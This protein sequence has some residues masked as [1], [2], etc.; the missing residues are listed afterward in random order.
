MNYIGIIGLLLTLFS[1]NLFAQDEKDR[2]H[3]KDGRI[4]EGIILEIQPNEFINLQLE[5]GTTTKIPLDEIDRV[6]RRSAHRISSTSP[7]GSVNIPHLFESSNYLP[8]ADNMGNL[9]RPKFATP[10]L[11]FDIG[12]I[13]PDFS[14]LD[15]LTD[16]SNSFFLCYRLGVGIPFDVH[17]KYSVLGQILSGVALSAGKDDTPSLLGLSCVFQ[18]RFM[19][20]N[21]NMQFSIGAGARYIA[22]RY[23][24]DVGIDLSSTYG[25]LQV[26]VTLIRDVL[27]IVCEY[28]I[29]TSPMRTIFDYS[30]YEVNP[31]G[32]S[33]VLRVSL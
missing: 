2:V 7:D 12:F 4:V 13:F 32:P 6:E 1:A 30:T 20:K 16:G 5:N 29:T 10:H 25:F 11:E 8:L 28:P 14:A 15:K 9:S 26:S 27:D 3:M 22:Y 21:T 33:I 31:A 17:G 23:Y 24:S 18:Y 19:P